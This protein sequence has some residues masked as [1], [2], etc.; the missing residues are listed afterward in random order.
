[1]PD[2]LVLSAPSIAVQLPTWQRALIGVLAR[3]APG[4]RLANRIP[5][6]VLSKDPAVGAG[7]VADPM[8]EHR[9]TAGFGALALAEQQHVAAG[10]DRLAIPTLVI[11]GGDD[12]LVPTSSSEPFEGQSGVTRRVYKGVRHELHNDLE[13]DTVLADVV[14]W[15][16]ANV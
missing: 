13:S 6:D 5:S 8:N 4:T 12:R 2:L 11:H 7:Y 3:V 9:T 16:R 10:L 15:I 1:M 14:A